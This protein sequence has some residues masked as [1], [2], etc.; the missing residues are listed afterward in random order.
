CHVMIAH[1]TPFLSKAWIKVVKRRSDAQPQSFYGCDKVRESRQPVNVEMEF[2][3]VPKR[4]LVVS[5][6]KRRVDFDLQFTKNFKV[7]L[8]AVGRRQFGGQ[9][10]QGDPH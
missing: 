2:L 3:V 1:P 10:L 4:P 7:L 6:V 5:P 8:G 9:S